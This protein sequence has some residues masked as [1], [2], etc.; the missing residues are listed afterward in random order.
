[1]LDGQTARFHL[2]FGVLLT[3]AFVIARFLPIG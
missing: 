1:M 2:L 3:V